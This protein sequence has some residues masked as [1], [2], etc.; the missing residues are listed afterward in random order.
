[1]RKLMDF[2]YYNI[3]VYIAYWFIDTVFD[4]FNLYS[5]HDLGQDL[6]VMPTSSDMVLI[7]INIVFSLVL[8]V[9]ALKKLKVLRGI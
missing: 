3:F 9:I 2:L 6:M 5:S 8:G 1:M 4:F 7:G